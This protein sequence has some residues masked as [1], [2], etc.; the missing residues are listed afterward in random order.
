LARRVT[1]SNTNSPWPNTGPRE[2]RSYGNNLFRRKS[3]LVAMGC[4]V[5]EAVRMTA[6]RA[7]PIRGAHTNKGKTTT[8]GYTLSSEPLLQIEYN[9]CRNRRRQVQPLF[10]KPTVSMDPFPQYRQAKIG[11]TMKR[12]NMIAILFVPEQWRC[13]SYQ[14][15]DR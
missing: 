13:K 14:L 15:T 1:S 3:L 5:E 12:L 9:S 6:F 2:L 10:P 4:R 8:Q 11:L 7:S